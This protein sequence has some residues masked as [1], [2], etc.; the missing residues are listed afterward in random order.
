MLH[1]TGAVLRAQ[2]QA[3][4]AYPP[5]PWSRPSL[6]GLRTRRAAQW[7]RKVWQT[8]QLPQRWER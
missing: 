8:G 2:G 7:E 5:S 4:P 1:L 6:S 3:K